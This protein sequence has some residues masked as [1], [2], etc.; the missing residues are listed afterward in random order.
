VTG[1]VHDVVSREATTVRSTWRIAAYTRWEQLNDERCRVASESRDELEFQI[2][3]K[4]LCEAKKAFEESYVSTRKA[5]EE[6]H[7]SNQWSRWRALQ[8]FYSGARIEQTWSCLHEAEHA[9]L[10]L[11]DEDVL[12][13]R[14]PFIRD[15]LRRHVDEHDSEFK[16]M[17][18]DLEELEKKVAYGRSDRERLRA[19]RAY[20]DSRSD[21]TQRD[22]RAFRN[23]LLVITVPL[24]VLLAIVAI[25]YAVDPSLITVCARD[26]ASLKMNQCPNGTTKAAGAD[27]VQIELIGA[28]AGLLSAIIPLRRARRLTGPYSIAIVQAALKMFTGAAIALIG[29]LLLQSDLLPG[30]SPQPGSRVLPYAAF[31][32]FAQQVLTRLVDQR[33]GELT[34]ATQTGTKSKT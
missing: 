29:V 17:G 27:V 8:Y 14:I 4:R 15:A 21:A 7:S 10:M 33:A 19:I 26:V 28:L 20:A 11:V 32:G 24:G 2:A 9:L 13:A 12:R 22:I 34:E 16:P 25:V 6:P 31:F 5:S 1:P 18:K 30:L 23:L 3:R